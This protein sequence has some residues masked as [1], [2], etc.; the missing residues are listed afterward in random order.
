MTQRLRPGSPL[1]GALAL[2][3]AGL[4]WMS[5][6]C[7]P[8]GAAPAQAD[9]RSAAPK[10]TDRSLKMPNSDWK[11][12]SDTELKQKLNPEQ[13]NVTQHEGTERPFRNEFWDNHKEG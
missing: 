13:Y 4:M 1:P 10:G 2:L 3:G 5:L 7:G 11:K 9:S 6:A 8:S 12:P